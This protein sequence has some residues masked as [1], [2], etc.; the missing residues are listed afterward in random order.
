MPKRP[1]KKCLTPS[2]P[3]K[4]YR[5]GICTHCY[6]SA[7]WQVKKGAATW[8]ELEELGL[9][10]KPTSGPN[11]PAAFVKEMKKRLKAAEERAAR[12]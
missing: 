1:D 11:R 4:G 6:N 9:V 10:D 2:C 12:A 8:E 7:A 5:R 3:E